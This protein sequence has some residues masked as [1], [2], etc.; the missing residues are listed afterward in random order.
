MNIKILQ[1]PPGKSTLANSPSKDRIL[2]A[3]KPKKF[4]LLSKKS[5]QVSELETAMNSSQSA[6]INIIKVKKTKKKQP[7]LSPIKENQ[8]I[9]KIDDFKNIEVI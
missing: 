2:S 7:E 9:L 8:A 3:K 5:Y 6:S 1:P 4:K